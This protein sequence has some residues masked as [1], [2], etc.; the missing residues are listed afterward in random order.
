M[1]SL[2]LPVVVV[3]RYRHP[4]FEGFARRSR[5]VGSTR[6]AL[7]RVAPEQSDSTPG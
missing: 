4:A 3:P 1:T 5:S 7:I 2:V 6:L